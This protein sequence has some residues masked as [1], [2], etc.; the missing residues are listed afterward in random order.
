MPRNHRGSAP[1]NVTWSRPVVA[2]VLSALVSWLPSRALSQAA[3]ERIDISSSGIY[4]LEIIRQADHDGQ[5]S[6]WNTI[7]NVR[8]ARA[9]SSIPLERCVSFGFEYVIVGA[10]AGAHIPM[11]MITRFPEPGLRNP[12]TG[13]LALTA[14]SLV[15]R[16][17]GW[18]HYRVYTFDDDWELIPGVW[19][20]EVW[21]GERQL[22]VQSFVLAPC[23]GD[24][25][26]PEEGWR[27]AKEL[28]GPLPKI[29]HLSRRTDMQLARNRSSQAYRGA[30]RVEP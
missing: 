26:R 13:Q 12:H 27:C 19:T 20:L 28:S 21:Q 9:T 10:P 3:I 11:R 22:A 25:Q 17:V 2:V 15:V 29:S 30:A 5:G 18:R 14:E 24:C 4:E 16:T 6:E 23:Q 1:L 8:L 7:A